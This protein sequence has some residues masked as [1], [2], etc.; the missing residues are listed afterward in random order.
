VM[1]V[2]HRGD[3]VETE[4]VELVDFHVESQVGKEETENF[5]RTVVEETSEGRILVQS[6]PIS[7]PREREE[8]EVSGTHESQSS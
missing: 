7:E 1:S 2:H 8:R 5:V 4:T 3:T 6:R